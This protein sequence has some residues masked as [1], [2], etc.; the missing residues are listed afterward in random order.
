VKNGHRTALFSGGDQQIRHLATAQA[1]IRK[2]TLHLLR[3][4]E[5]LWLDL[6]EVEC[7]E[8]HRQRIE[9]A[10]VAGREP[11]LQV[12]DRRSGD[13]LALLEQQSDLRPDRVDAQPRDHAGVQQRRHRQACSRSASSTVA[14]TSRAL[15]IA[16]WPWRAAARRASFTVSL[17][18]P[19]PNSI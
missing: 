14:R 17:I 18:V 10:C 9:L 11:N 15:V 19:V 5:V 16:R 12:R 1:S 13:D 7:L 8:R 2:E 6:D 4:T 3:S